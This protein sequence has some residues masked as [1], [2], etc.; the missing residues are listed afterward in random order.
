M[1]NIILCGGTIKELAQTIKKIV[2]YKGELY[3]N[4]TKLD[5]TMVKLTDPSKLHSL[6]WKN[7]VELEERI[8]RIYEWCLKSK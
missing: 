7:V 4:D 8:A 6:G 1:T 5:G 3:F 2:G